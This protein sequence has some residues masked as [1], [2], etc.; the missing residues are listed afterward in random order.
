MTTKDLKNRENILKEKIFLK[1]EEIS[2]KD[3]LN[4]T[5]DLMIEQT[6]NRESEAAYFYFLTTF[7]FIL[8]GFITMWF[9]ATRFDSF[10]VYFNEFF[11]KSKKY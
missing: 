4:K 6:I 7:V 8:G 1:N 2:V 5:K 11:C 10:S 9:L 3:L